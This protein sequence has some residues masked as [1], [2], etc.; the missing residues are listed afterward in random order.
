VDTGRWTFNWFENDTAR[1]TVRESK[2]AYSGLGRDLTAGIFSPEIRAEGVVL[3][4][5]TAAGPISPGIAPLPSV[6][7]FV[8]ELMK[9]TNIVVASTA[10]I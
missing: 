10:T 3:S 8:G 1:R 2:I 7:K 6:E 5:L 4:P 9:F